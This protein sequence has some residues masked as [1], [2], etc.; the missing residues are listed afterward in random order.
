MKLLNVQ[1]QFVCL[2]AEICRNTLKSCMNPFLL[3][4]PDS[5]QTP[6]NQISISESLKVENHSTGFLYPR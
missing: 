5:H 4:L 2:I 1:G 6:K 3:L